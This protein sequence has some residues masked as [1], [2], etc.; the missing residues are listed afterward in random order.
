MA[1]T[2]A[3]RIPSLIYGTAWKKDKTQD[4]VRQAIRAGFRGIDTAA[5]PKHYEEDLVGNGIRDAIREGKVTRHSLY[6]GSSLKTSFP[7]TKAYND[8]RSNPNSPQS[9][10]KTRQGSRTTL[11][12]ASQ[13]RSTPPSPHLYTIS[14]TKT[15]SPRMMSPRN[16]TSTVWSCTPPCQI[17]SRPPKPGRQWSRTCRNLRSPWASPTYTRYLYYKSYAPGRKSN[18]LSCRTASSLAAGMTRM[19][20]HSVRSKASRIRASGR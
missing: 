4:L 10:D 7:A 8:N 6:V 15:T 19:S 3:A 18:L 1:P 16:P 5:Q 13:N 20:G 9:M 14:A 17:P 12:A 11:A 2:K